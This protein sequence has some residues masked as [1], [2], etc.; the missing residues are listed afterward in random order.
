[1]KRLLGHRLRSTVVKFE[2]VLSC[3]LYSG[4]RRL[5]AGPLL[6]IEPNHHGYNLNKQKE[7]QT[8][9]TSQVFRH[10]S[11]MMDWQRP[12]KL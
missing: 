1:M 9:F 3:L 2:S 8:L 11:Q 10:K 12:I 5:I 6:A 7:T 4:K